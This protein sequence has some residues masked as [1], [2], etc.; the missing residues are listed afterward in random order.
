MEQT[1]QQ[2]SNVAVVGPDTK[3]TLFEG[4]Q[5]V[6]TRTNDQVPTGYIAST[7]IP[8]KC[9]EHIPVPKLEREKKYRPIESESILSNSNGYVNQAEAQTTFKPK[10]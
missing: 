6:Q 5:F 4:N 7:P 2:S 9:W 10:N 3:N 8:N 1:W